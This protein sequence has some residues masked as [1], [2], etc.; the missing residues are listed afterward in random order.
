MQRK[1]QRPQFLFIELTPISG[2]FWLNTLAS[3]YFLILVPL[4]SLPNRST[5]RFWTL[6]GEWDV[7]AFSARTTY[8]HGQRTHTST[9]EIHQAFLPQKCCS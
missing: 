1:F 7:T 9:Q 2:K 4:K 3:V 5:C 8:H 6:P